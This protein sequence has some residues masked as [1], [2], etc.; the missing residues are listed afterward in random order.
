[1]LSS[2]QGPWRRFLLS[3]TPKQCLHG[4]L[5]GDPVQLLRH[6]LDRAQVRPQEHSPVLQQSQVW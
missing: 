2:C 3:S 5:R 4:V 1:M 6:V